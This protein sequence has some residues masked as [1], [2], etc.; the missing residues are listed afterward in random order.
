[1]VKIELNKDEKETIKF[2][3]QQHLEEYKKEEI[4]RDV[5]LK[6]LQAEEKYEEW[7]EKL[8]KKF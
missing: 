6:F 4:K 3:L 1:M 5:P 8:I 7:L 2:I